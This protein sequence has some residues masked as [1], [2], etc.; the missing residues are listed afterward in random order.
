M[1]RILV[2]LDSSG[3]PAS[4]LPAARQ[5]AAPGDELVLACILQ[6]IDLLGESEGVYGGEPDLQREIETL[7]KS[8]VSVRAE[9]L[10]ARDLPAAIS[11]AV[12]RFHPDLVANAAQLA[13]E[14]APPLAKASGA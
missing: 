1:R 8:G 12:E 7:R 13:A 9:L 4:I 10:P 2:L 11:R 5:Y 3:L 6:P 14:V